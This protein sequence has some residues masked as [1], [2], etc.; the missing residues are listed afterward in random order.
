VRLLSA[1]LAP[2]VRASL[3]SAAKYH[4]WGKVDLRYQAWLR[5]GDT[6]AARYA[7]EPIAKSGRHR[8]PRQTSAGL[9]AGFRHESLS[10]LFA[11]KGGADELAL[12]EVGAHHGECRPFAPAVMDASA[13]C[14]EY[15]GIEVCSAE[16]RDR[17]AHRLS[18]GVA[19]RFWRLTRE[20]GWWGLAYLDAIF[21]IADWNASGEGAE[22]GG[23]DDGCAASGA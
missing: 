4:D 7:P 17:A 13:G 1:H 8:L 12:H 16:Q 14:V 19:D 23:V 9:P 2:E 11:E 15:D 5:G 10:I 3:E 18:S 20:Y 22:E 6:L 21:R